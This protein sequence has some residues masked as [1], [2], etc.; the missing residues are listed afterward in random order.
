MDI[1]SDTITYRTTKL[2]KI[3][4]LNFYTELSGLFLRCS[5]HLIIFLNEI[6]VLSK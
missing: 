6:L 1:L 5:K 2:G 3:Q 4:F